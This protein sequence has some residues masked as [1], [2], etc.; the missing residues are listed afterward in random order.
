MHWDVV[1]STVKWSY[2]GAP[3][4]Q[5]LVAFAFRLRPLQS[6]IH[7][8]PPAIS[9]KIYP[10]VASPLHPRSSWP[11]ALAA[12]DLKPV[13]RQDTHLPTPTV[14]M[15]IGSWLRCIAWQWL[16]QSHA[17]HPMAPLCVIFPTNLPAVARRGVSSLKAWGDSLKAVTEVGTHWFL[18]LR[19]QKSRWP[20]KGLV[21]D[22]SSLLRLGSAVSNFNSTGGSCFLHIRH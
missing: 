3:F 4:W 19:L 6:A 14:Q 9:D 20:A 2:Q 12:P 15:P 1:F 16:N 5:H 10:S 8:L 18:R 13:S 17:S 22:I 21:Q 7:L 11:E